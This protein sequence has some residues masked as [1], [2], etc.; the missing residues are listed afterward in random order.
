[1]SARKLALMAALC[2]VVSLTSIEARAAYPERPVTFL[3]GVAA[4]GSVDTVARFLARQLTDKWRSNVVVENR[5]GASGAIAFDALAHA[6]PDGYT[7]GF[8]NDSFAVV[9]FQNKVTFDSYKDFTP[10]TRITAA[11]QV[12]V[13]NPDSSKVNTLREFIALAKANPG[14]F[15]FGS[16]GQGT[17]P[18]L[19]MAQFAKSTDLDMVSISYDGVPASLIALLRGDIH[20][21]FGT[22][23]TVAAQLKE[24]KIKALAV[25]ENRRAA[26]FPD[27]PTVAEAAGL[28]DFDEG[29]WYGLLAPAATPA[30]IV[31]KIADD[32]R[33]VLENPEVQKTLA[34]QGFRTAPMTPAEFRA[35][36][37]GKLRKMQELVRSLPKQ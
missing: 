9:P 24:G 11:T 32:T 16:G 35:F 34:G 5:P 14:K 13:V 20:A 6:K 31:T 7:L 19:A 26:N 30:D 4:G 23:G 33:A 1:M 3:V 10:I 22:E 18:Y 15:N 2:S 12:F 27:I 36:T 29:I 28:P 37:D 17:A 21:L 8:V 25:G